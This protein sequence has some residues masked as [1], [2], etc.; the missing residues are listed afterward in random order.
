MCVCVSVC[1]S[2]CMCVCVCVC[3]GVGG[4]VGP[5]PRLF[6]TRE[7]K[8]SIRRDRQN[9]IKY[10]GGVKEGEDFFICD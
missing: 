8:S 2:V 1:E 10:P 9:V 7:Y 6:G 3:E 5:H 4:C